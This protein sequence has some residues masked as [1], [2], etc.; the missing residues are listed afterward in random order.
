MLRTLL[1]V[2]FC[3]GCNASHSMQENTFEWLSALSA[4]QKFPVEIIKGE[5]RDSTGDIIAR[6]P[7]ESYTAPGWGQISSTDVVG[8]DKKP[9]PEQLYLKW[10][11]LTER[12]TYEGTFDLRPLHLD[13][14]FENG[15]YNILDDK[16]GTYEFIAAGIAPKGNVVL[17]LISGGE[18]IMVGTFKAMETNVLDTFKICGHTP[19]EEHIKLQIGARLTPDERDLK[20]DP[21]EIN[22]WGNEYLL[23][24]NWQPSIIISRPVLNFSAAFFSGEE[25]GWKDAAA[26][27]ASGP[28]RVPREMTVTWLDED[29]KKV[30]SEIT[31]DE[32]KIFA[33]FKRISSE[34]TAKLYVQTEINKVTYA[35]RTYLHDKVHMVDL[36][37]CTYKTY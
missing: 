20:I 32:E 17:Y 28:L 26:A 19:I 23:Q 24:Y 13:Q 10:L 11:S 6:T 33:A 4:P 8:P 22:K 37:K 34:S 2:L 21:Y 7:M 18:H 5:F 14:Y 25:T 31:F 15:F 16:H 12:K 29:G 9:L 36:T 30:I 3:T 1:I 27:E 35:V